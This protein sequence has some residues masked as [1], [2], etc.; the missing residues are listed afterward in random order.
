MF[1]EI[2]KGLEIGWNKIK[3]KGQEKS[4]IIERT[5]KSANFL[6]HA[7]ITPLPLV[8]TVFSSLSSDFA[9]KEGWPFGLA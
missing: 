9:A 5:E 6:Y 7:S 3:R 8:T 4:K 2:I 1:T